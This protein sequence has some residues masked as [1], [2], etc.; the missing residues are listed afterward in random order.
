MKLK[1]LWLAYCLEN[2]W[3]GSFYRLNHEI[4]FDMFWRRKAKKIVFLEGYT[5]QVINRW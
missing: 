4:K 3:Y 2:M 5:L 1:L